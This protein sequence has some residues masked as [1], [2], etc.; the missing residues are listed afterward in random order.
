MVLLR[1]F[2]YVFCA[3]VSLSTL[4]ILGW[5]YWQTLRGVALL[6]IIGLALAD[7]VLWFASHFSV[8]AGGALRSIALVVKFTMA[9]V[10]L[11]TAGGVVYVTREDERATVAQTLAA[12]ASVAEIEAR[13]RAAKELAALAGGRAAAREIAR[14]SPRVA[15]V[16]PGGVPGWVR[17][18]VYLVP[19]LCA[20]FG[21]LALSLAGLTVPIV[22]PS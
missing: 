7:C 11:T 18:A 20:L 13:S 12:S 10:M 19:S 17:L 4:P 16:E 14:T 9:A 22:R 5:H 2:A 1:V 21:A 3:L 6:S 15:P 8:T